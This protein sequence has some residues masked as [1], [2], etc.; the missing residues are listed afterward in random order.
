MDEQRRSALGFDITEDEPLL[1]NGV[2]I[3]IKKLT[4]SAA[5]SFESTAFIQTLR[6]T[7]A[8]DYSLHLNRGLKIFVN[9]VEVSGWRIELRQSDEF[10]PM[11]I[12]YMDESGG[13]DVRI[14]LIGGMA[15]PPPD[16]IEPDESEDGDK[17]FGWYV[18]CNGRV[19]LAADKTSVAGWGT[20]DWPQWHRQYSGFIGVILFTAANALALPLTTTKR[21]I[22]TTSEI[23][24]RAQ[25]RMRELSKAWIAYTNAKKQAL[26]DAKQKE[27]LARTVSI[28]DVSRQHSPRFPALVARQSEK[29][30]NVHYSVS[31]TKL[32]KLG[33]ELGSMHMSFMDIGLKSFDYTY[34]D[35]VGDE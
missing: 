22:D 7:I 20:L 31:V 32:R 25:P 33:S 1:D 4:P 23:Y 9:D 8:R 27:G 26:E 28:Y 10:A 11:R 14:E 17:T 29:V 6:R 5:A 12:E 34:R 18:V 24:R 35:M 21:S 3:V 15:A 16:D 19:V 30:G 2:E 13:S